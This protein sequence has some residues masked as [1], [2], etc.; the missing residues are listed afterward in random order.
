MSLTNGKS[1]PPSSSAP[2]TKA[3]PGSAQSMKVPHTTSSG[4]TCPGDGRCDGTGGTT[5]CSGCPTYN[6]VL[7]LSARIELEQAAAEANAAVAAGVAAAAAAGAS[8]NAPMDGVEGYG[9]GSASPKMDNAASPAA[10]D[11]DASVGAAAQSRKAR[12]VVGALCCAN[13]S[14]S[15]TPLWR[16]DD[17]GNNICNAC[18]TS[19]SRRPFVRF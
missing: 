19:P 5:A 16:R 13:C 10:A 4:G 1:T 6:N 3:S 11:S 8:G 7:A 18:G 2:G 14:T 15:T 12:P 17:V 9:K